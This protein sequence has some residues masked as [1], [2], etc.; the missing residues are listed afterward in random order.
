[1]LYGVTDGKRLAFS[2]V[3]E[4]PGAMREFREKSRVM[5]GA[6]IERALVRIAHEIV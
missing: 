5:D 6:A 2:Q 3:G 1:M 4:G